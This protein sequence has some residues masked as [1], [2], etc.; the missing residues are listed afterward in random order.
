MCTVVVQ[1]STQYVQVVLS[2]LSLASPRVSRV[3][4]RW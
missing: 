1:E 2:L 4:G 3:D